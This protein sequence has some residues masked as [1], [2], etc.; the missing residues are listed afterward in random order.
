MIPAKPQTS[1][2]D[3]KAETRTMQVW[4]GDAKAAVMARTL[5]LRAQKRAETGLCEVMIRRKRVGQVALFHHH[6]G[7]AVGERPF[8]V[9]AVLFGVP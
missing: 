5:K 9:R 8:F 6:E 7:N 4:G 1:S 2:H 3:G